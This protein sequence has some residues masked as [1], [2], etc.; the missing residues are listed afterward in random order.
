MFK[1]AKI[2]GITAFLCIVMCLSLTGPSVAGKIAS[3]RSGE[4]IGGAYTNDKTGK[5]SHCAYERR[6]PTGTQLLFSITAD[7][8]WSVG[9]GHGDWQL[10]IGERHNVHYKIDNGKLR[11]GTAWV[12]TPHMAQIILPNSSRLVKTFHTGH[13]LTIST[14]KSQMRFGLKDF[15]RTLRV[16]MECAKHYASLKNSR[17]L[18]Q[19]AKALAFKLGETRDPFRYR[20]LANRT[21]TPLDEFRIEAQNAIFALMEKA[22]LNFQ[23]I[24][25]SESPK[26]YRKAHFAWRMGNEVVGTLRI[27]EKRGETMMRIASGI[28]NG[29][30]RSCKGRFASQIV[31]PE[32]AKAYDMVTVCDSIPGRQGV[33]IYYAIIPRKPGGFYMLSLASPA[34]NQHFL[35]ERGAHLKDL[36]L[37]LSERG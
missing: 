26:Y 6:Y 1:F 34:K 8:R 25:A 21:G 31:S 32:S 15:S 27:I 3:L 10:K 28:K 13:M 5:F 29:D 16:M 7:R 35:R 14:P 36:A 20:D 4:W 17:V 2:P 24:F 11:R 19:P 9:F 23:I 30:G 37:E 22:D 33:S 18:N 12:K